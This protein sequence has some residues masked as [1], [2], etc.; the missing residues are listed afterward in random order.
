LDGHRVGSF[1]YEVLEFAAL[2]AER[3]TV[4][5]RAMTG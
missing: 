2:L 1:K 4:G 5:K 3:Q